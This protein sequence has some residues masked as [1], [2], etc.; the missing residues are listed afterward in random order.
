MM[1][2]ELKLYLQE[3][4]RRLVAQ[5][6]LA[7]LRAIGSVPGAG[8]PP[9]PSSEDRTQTSML[10]QLRELERRFADIERKLGP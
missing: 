9:F 7:A 10:N 6:G 8:P 2:E 5:M 4:E 3:M 1:E